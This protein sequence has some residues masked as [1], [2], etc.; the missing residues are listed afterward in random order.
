LLLLLF[1]LVFLLRFHSL[2]SFRLFFFVV[3]SFNTVFSF[4]YNFYH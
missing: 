3:F 1:G 2:V 4:P